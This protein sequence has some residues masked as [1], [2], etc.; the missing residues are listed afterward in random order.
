MQN[1]MIITEEAIKNVLSRVTGNKGYSR[2][3][4]KNIHTKYYILLQICIYIFHLNWQNAI[5]FFYNVSTLF[6]PCY[7]TGDKLFFASGKI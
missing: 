4:T 6:N 5:P 3:K 1:V 2:H 7:A